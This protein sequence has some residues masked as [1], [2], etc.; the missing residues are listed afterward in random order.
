MGFV[1]LQLPNAKP[2]GLYEF[3]IIVKNKNVRRLMI[4]APFSLSRTIHEDCPDYNVLHIAITPLHVENPT[5]QVVGRVHQQR[6]QSQW[7]PSIS[8]GERKS[9]TSTNVLIKERLHRKRRK[10]H[11]VLGFIQEEERID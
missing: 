2:L 6:I 5:R 1:E 9:D 7:D 3:F 4:N 8:E 11:G 10:N